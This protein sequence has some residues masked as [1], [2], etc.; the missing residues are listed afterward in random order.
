MRT[1]DKNM[2]LAAGIG[3]SMAISP[4][5]ATPAFLA[6]VFSPVISALYLA[7]DHKIGAKVAHS[8]AAGG[9][10]LMM[11]TVGLWAGSKIHGADSYLTETDQ[12]VTTEQ[13]QS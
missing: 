8:A 3:G 13:V 9:L 11:I 1:V 6:F 12:Y 4:V 10:S 5:L 2:I 7:K